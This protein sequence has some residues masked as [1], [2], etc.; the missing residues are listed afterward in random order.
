MALI[1]TA[2]GQVHRG[3][4]VHEAADRLI[5]QAGA[6][7]TVRVAGD[8]T[9]GRRDAPG[10]LMPAGLLDKLSDREIADLHAFPRSQGAPDAPPR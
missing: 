7:P 1:A 2:D 4:V 3:M 8:Q 10:S 6:T 5:L 9:V